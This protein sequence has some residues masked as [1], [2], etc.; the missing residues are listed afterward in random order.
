MSSKYDTLKPGPLYAT[1]HPLSHT[2]TYSPKMTPDHALKLFNKKLLTSEQL[3][4]YFLT[5]T[6]VK[7]TKS[8]DGFTNG[9]TSMTNSRTMCHLDRYYPKKHWDDLTPL[10]FS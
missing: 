7:P 9:N 6:S 2:T 3:S 5:S 4:K 8:F 10:K 1:N